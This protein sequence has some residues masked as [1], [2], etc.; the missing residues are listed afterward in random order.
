MG[1]AAPVLHLR[2]RLVL[3]PLVGGLD[4]SHRK[5]HTAVGQAHLGSRAV[6]EVEVAV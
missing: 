3:Q 5:D 2:R 1:R 4:P 6:M